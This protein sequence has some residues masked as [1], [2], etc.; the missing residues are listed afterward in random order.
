M[1]F[2]VATPSRAANRVRPIAIQQ[3]R[4]RLVPIQNNGP[5]LGVTG[6][7]RGQRLRS[8]PLWRSPENLAGFIILRGIALPLSP[9]IS[10]ALA[11]LAYRSLTKG[12]G[13]EHGPHRRAHGVALTLRHPEDAI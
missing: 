8:Y 4:P 12:K 6:A 7:A 1:S 9:L 11:A 3:S 10:L 13:K 2:R 5:R